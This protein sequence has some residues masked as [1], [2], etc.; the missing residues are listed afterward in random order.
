MPLGHTAARADTVIRQLTVSRWMSDDAC[1][2]LVAYS[3]HR[4][5][6]HG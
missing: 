4:Y 5:T 2:T 3:R 1:I 6:D